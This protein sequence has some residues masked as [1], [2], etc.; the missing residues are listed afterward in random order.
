[1]ESSLPHGAIVG[2]VYISRAATLDQCAGNAWATGPV[3]NMIAARCWLRKP[4]SHRGSLGVWK[5]T[6]EALKQVRAQLQFA[7]IK[8][9]ESLPIEHE[10]TAPRPE[11]APAQ[12]RT[13]SGAG[14]DHS[15]GADDGAH[16]D[17]QVRRI[18]G[19]VRAYHNGDTPHVRS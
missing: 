13:P 1:M 19:M 7:H 15:H 9:N 2:A 3:C 4:I 14:V 16:I 17:A 8:R 6:A 18:F 5:L 12:K 11:I 10:K